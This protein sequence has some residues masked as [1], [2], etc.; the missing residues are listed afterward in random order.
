MVLA[1]LGV[2]AY[3]GERALL[4]NQTRFAGIRH[5]HTQRSVH[6]HTVHLASLG[7]LPTLCAGCGAGIRAS[8]RKLHC[9]AVNRLECEEV[10][11]PLATLVPDHYNVDTA[12]LS[13]ALRAVKLFT[14][15]SQVWKKRNCTQTTAFGNRRCGAIQTTTPLLH[16]PRRTRSTRSSR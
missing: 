4:K 6:C 13:R 12:G 8:S 10:L 5:G 14:A 2:G 1:E 16:R 9:M 15:L 7:P 11:G 3:F